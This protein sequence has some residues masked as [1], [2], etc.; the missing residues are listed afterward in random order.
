MKPPILWR[1][2]E[3]VSILVVDDNAT[4]REISCERYPFGKARIDFIDEGLL[5]DV[6]SHLTNSLWN[7]HEES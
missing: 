5:T 6:S 3:G 4:N 1:W 7:R 2:N